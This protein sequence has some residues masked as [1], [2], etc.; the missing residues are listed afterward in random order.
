[1]SQK[2]L[3]SGHQV[4]V[5]DSLRFGGQALLPLLAEP[6]FRFFPGDV[7]DPEAVARALDG[8]DAVVHLAAVVGDPNCA[9]EPELAV[10][11]N[12]EA[13]LALLRAV[14]KRRMVF[15][16]T[17]SNYGRMADTSVLA[18]E[19]HEL[20][21][22]SLYAETKVAVE[23]ALLEAG[24]TVLR[25]AT[26][27]GLAART[28]F[29]LTV[30]QFAAEMQVLGKITVFGEQFWRPYVHVQDAAAGI[31]LALSSPREKVAGEVFN[32]GATTENYRKQDIIELVQQRLRRKAEVI[33]V[34]RN[35]DPRDYR[36]SFDKI[37]TRLGF[38]PERTVAH[39]IDEVVSAFESGI[40]RPSE[41]GA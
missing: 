16:S 31:A 26:L 29:D 17:C 12:Q 18:T 1:M 21:P 5:L 34:A 41:I 40:F 11:V 20:R 24:H 25:F 6:G 7:R 14:G 27:Y 3:R 35:E 32:V 38:K 23:R 30:N 28:R 36:V 33:R 19:E 9:A 8:V 37:A 39:G 15:A 2:L 22:V 10:A 13:S 4:R